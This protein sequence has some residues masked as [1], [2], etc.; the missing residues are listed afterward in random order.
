MKGSFYLASVTRTYRRAIDR[1]LDS[2]GEFQVD[3]D[4]MEDLLKVS[5]RPYTKGL[6]FDGPEISTSGIE[7]R[8]SYIQ[9]HTLAGL[10]RS[11]PGRDLFTDEGGTGNKIHFEARS[12][13]VPGINLE[14]LYPDGTSRFHVLQSFEDAN[15]NF[16]HEA[17][18][19]RWI[20]F[21]VDF[22]VLPFQV[23]RIAKNDC[24]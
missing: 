21:S 15:G 18:P 2:P 22:P 11:F 5:H 8:V 20:R 1:Y 12:R 23:V 14:F 9:T 19:N 4:W 24:R 13:L 7:T 16:L 6:L 3:P 10:V 17:H